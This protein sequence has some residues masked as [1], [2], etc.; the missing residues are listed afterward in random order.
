MQPF[1]VKLSRRA[2]SRLRAT[3]ALK[4]RVTARAGDSALQT[5]VKLR[6]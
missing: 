6:R 4:L 5:K 1:A 2:R 3:G